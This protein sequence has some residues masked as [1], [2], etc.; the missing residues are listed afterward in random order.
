MAALGVLAV[1]GLFG[2][3]TAYGGAHYLV[4]GIIGVVLGST[5]GWIGARRRWPLLV[6]LA[7][8]ILA[9]FLVGGPVAV[10]STT[11]AGVVPTPSTLGA[12]ADGA[13]QGWKKLLTSEPPVGSSANLL[14]VP[15]LLGL[16]ASVLQVSIA[17]RSRRH[18]L[19]V[20]VPLGVVA[21]SILFGTL[22]PASVLIQGAGVAMLS[23]WWLSWAQR[24]RR[25]VASG[26][27]RWVGGVAV[28]A[29]AALFTTVV[30]ELG[31]IPG[32]G[33]RD[34]VV[35]REYTEPEFNPADYPSPLSTFRRYTD[36]TIYAA[37]A[38]EDPTDDPAT[39]SASTGSGLGGETLFRISGDLRTDEPIRLAVMDTYRDGVV[40]EVGSGPD[41]SGVFERV[42]ERLPGEGEGDERKVQIEVLTEDF[43]EIWVP[44]LDGL[45]GIE[46]L[47]NG[48]RAD[49]LREALRVNLETGTAAVPTRL[50][51]GD[52]Y[53]LAVVSTEEAKDQWA[54]DRAARNDA[55]PFGVAAVAEI[56]EQLSRDEPC[57][58]VEGAGPVPT[59][60][61]SATSSPYQRVELLARRLVYCGGLS[62][63]GGPLGQESSDPGHHAGRLADMAE[64]LVGNGEQFAPL[65]ALLAE[66]LGVP[67]RVVMG[68][69]SEE[70]S[71]VWRATRGQEPSDGDDGRYDVT[72]ADV[73]AWIEIELAESGWIPIESV[74]PTQIEPAPRPEP[75]P[76]GS[77]IDP[78]P[79]PPSIPPSEDEMAQET[80]PCT[81]DCPETPPAPWEWPVWLKALGIA[82]L[83]FA[84]VGAVTGLIAGLKARRRNRRRSAGDPTDRVEGGWDEIRDL[85]TD[86]GSPLPDRTTRFEGARF[87]G[88]PE[89]VTLARRAD[90]LIFGPGT[91]DD[92]RVANY[93]NEVDATRS[94]MVSD[95]GR[96]GRWKVLVSLSSLRAGRSGRTAG[97]ARRG[98][99]PSPGPFRRRGPQGA[100]S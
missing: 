97:A 33:W 66:N 39:Q 7:A 15:F 21:L 85:A 24:D 62:D 5:I 20:F 74:V 60:E 23:L 29:G 52:R 83:P 49:T 43:D 18:L 48:E 81:E 86:L 90:A 41:S 30:G 19:A 8:M 61:S 64:D 34:R 88:R 54:K 63:G 11:V 26:R 92:Q 84:L 96:F 57:D 58:P 3:G 37:D 100:V 25:L 73:T 12:L 2:F 82:S 44:V 13:V 22:E 40:Y 95:L 56:E 31:V 68:F 27:R 69:R 67:S 35:L 87:V 98:R 6:V 79:P 14:V 45:S 53:E 59:L 4:A 80:P 47:G 89:A 38:V 17:L 50:E 16:F 76:T 51:K 55:Q 94:A 78:P 91:P 46:F 71:N 36:G 42:G 65:A 70:D 72:G 1:L 9:F 10:S 28:L 75:P 32:S 93:W 99:L 77:E